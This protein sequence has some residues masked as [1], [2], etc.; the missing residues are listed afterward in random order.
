MFGV[1]PKMLKNGMVVILPKSSD[2]VLSDVKSYQYLVSIGKAFEKLINRRIFRVNGSK[3]RFS[4]KNNGSRHG[5]STEDAVCYLNK[6]VMLL[7]VQYFL[8]VLI[9][10][11]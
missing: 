3:G 7:H 1:S 2:R 10:L 4:S 8:Y 11:I 9:Y 5:T 6:N